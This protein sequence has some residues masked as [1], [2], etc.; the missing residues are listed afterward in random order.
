MFLWRPGGVTTDIIT[1]SGGGL[2][3]TSSGEMLRTGMPLTS[4][5]RSPVWTEDSRSGLRTVESN[6]RRE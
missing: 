5:T 6:L 2:K 4:S 3:P 1:K